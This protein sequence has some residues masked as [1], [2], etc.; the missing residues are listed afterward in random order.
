MHRAR[1]RNISDIG[2]IILREISVTK[3]QMLYK[4]SRT[5]EYIETESRAVAP[6]GLRGGE[7]GYCYLMQTEF[8]FGKMK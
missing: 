6:R 2:G 7:E 8:Q 4:V 1:R 3:R 5:V